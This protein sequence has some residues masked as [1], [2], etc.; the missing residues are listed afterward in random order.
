[1]ATS[2]RRLSVEG[3]HAALSRHWSN[4]EWWCWIICSKRTPNWG[5]SAHEMDSWPLNIDLLAFSWFDLGRFSEIVCRNV[6]LRAAESGTLT[7]EMVAVESGRPTAAASGTL[8]TSESPREQ[9]N[10]MSPSRLAR[11]ATRPIWHARFHWWHW[12]QDDV[13]AFE[14]LDVWGWNHVWGAKES[15]GSA[16]TTLAINCTTL[17]RGIWQRDLRSCLRTCAAR[18]LKS[19]SG[20][21]LAYSSI[22]LS[23]KSKVAMF[24]SFYLHGKGR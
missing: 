8:N 18:S 1:M 2:H 10:Q 19:H 11:K 17:L 16:T 13:L 5:L 24:V 3:T 22:L 7:P 9:T 23:W 14:N 20:G 4:S 21:P 12:I 15:N 6:L